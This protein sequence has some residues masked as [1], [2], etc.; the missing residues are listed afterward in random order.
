M[1]WWNYSPT[2]EFIQSKNWNLRLPGVGSH[3]DVTTKKRH[4]CSFFY[5]LFASVATLEYS[6]LFSFYLLFFRQLFSS[7]FLD[8][9]VVFFLAYSVAARIGFI[10]H[11]WAVFS[12][13][14][15]N[16]GISILSLLVKSLEKWNVLYQ[17]TGL[18]CQWKSDDS[19]RVRVALELWALLSWWQKCSFRSNIANAHAIRMFNT[20]QINNQIR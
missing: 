11:F 12:G 14:F 17:S 8:K 10:P 1:I 3:K 2:L 16:F 15:L 5:I 9:R 13:F 4:C 19:S 6:I 20:Y 18:F 7:N